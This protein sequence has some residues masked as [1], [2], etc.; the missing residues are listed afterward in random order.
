M[1]TLHIIFILLLS[2]LGIN[3][4]S[5]ETGFAPLTEGGKMYYEIRGTGEP[6]I[7]LHGHTLDRR[8]WNPQIVEFSKHFKVITIDFRGYGLSS[9]QT[10]TL[11]TTHVDDLLSLMNYLRIEKAHIVGL[12]MGGFV[13]GDMVGMYPERMLSC[14]M[15]SGALRSQ[16]K[17][18][19]EPIDPEET[20]EQRA[21]L[22]QIKNQGVENWRHDWIEQLITKGG[23]QQETIR[24]PLTEMIMDW[25]CFQIT[26][27]EPRLYYG[28]EAMQN[29]MEKRPEVPTMYLSGET[30]HKKSMGMLR[31][32][33]ISK[34]VELTDC[35]HM[36]NMEQPEQFNKVV[37]DFLLTYSR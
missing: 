2:V 3:A 6:L 4:Q 36:S 15:C 9:K 1:K 30:E 37:L 14:V 22:M 7:L 18:I 20:E 17:S 26:H 16:H 27:I 23:S 35:G 10:E 21:K 5:V 29:L 11:K 34:Q 19:N 24:K 28:R 32:L 12:S 25:D 8:M 13:A 33:P 31:Y